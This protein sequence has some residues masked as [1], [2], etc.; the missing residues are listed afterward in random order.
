M[1]FAIPP[2]WSPQYCPRFVHVKTINDEISQKVS[3]WIDSYEEDDDI[4]DQLST[5]I[6]EGIVPG[7]YMDEEKSDVR[8]PNEYL[9][10]SGYNKRYSTSHNSLKA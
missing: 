1:T 5:F 2:N 3:L 9:V 7:F 6:T 10:I 4:L 8:N